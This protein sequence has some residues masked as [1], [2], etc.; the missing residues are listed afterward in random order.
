ML[1]NRFL[2]MTYE[3]GTKESFL[4]NINIP[5]TDNNNRQITE[6]KLEAEETENDDYYREN[7]KDITLTAFAIDN[8]IYFAINFSQ[9]QR[10]NVNVSFTNDNLPIIKENSR[11]NTKIDTL[12]TFGLKELQNLYW[13]YRPTTLLS[14][15]RTYDNNQVYMA[16]KKDQFSKFHLYL[17]NL[18]DP[19]FILK[20]TNTQ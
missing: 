18:Y 1:R 15:F 16:R 2:T 10:L 19:I 14:K 11:S 5:E 20:L 3:D 13:E 4:L 6:W 17:D 9:L 8:D 7:S 12:K